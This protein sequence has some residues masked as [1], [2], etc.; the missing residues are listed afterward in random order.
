M[1]T[2]NLHGLKVDRS[3]LH[4][5]SFAGLPLLSELAH[6]TGLIDRLDAIPGLWERSGAHKT[7]DYVMSL[8]MTLIAGGEG[9]DDTRLLRTDPGLGQLVF[10]KMPAANSLGASS[11]ASATAASTIWA[12]PSR[13]RPCATSRATGS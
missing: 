6:H 1:V 10:P 11:G 5:T 13:P 9:L 2:Q 12:R 8:A 3:L 4:L 7:S